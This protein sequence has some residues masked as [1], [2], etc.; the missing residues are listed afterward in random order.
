MNLNETVQ[1]AYE[2]FETNVRKLDQLISQLE[3][4]SDEYTINHKKEEVRVP[5]YIELHLNLEAFKGELEEQINELSKEEALKEAIENAQAHIEERLQAY[6]ET[7]A[8]IHDW[9][10][11]IK[12]PYMLINNI[13]VVQKNKEFIESILNA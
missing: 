5:E 8:I 6:E 7:E 13:S 2:E 11:E 3:L 12:N 9:I 1:M 10:R 4:W